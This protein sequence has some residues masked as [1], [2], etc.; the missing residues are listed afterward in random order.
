MRY[1]KRN[2][3]SI[4]AVISLNENG[5]IPGSPMAVPS[6]F[7]TDLRKKNKEVLTKVHKASSTPAQP[8]KPYTC[9]YFSY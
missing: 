9:Y 1:L 3:K 8:H 2:K 7:S 6:L 5:I 4:C